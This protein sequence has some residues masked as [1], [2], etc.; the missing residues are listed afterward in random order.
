MISNANRLLATAETGLQRYTISHIAYQLLSDIFRSTADDVED[1][2]RREK[3]MAPL[4]LPAFNQDDYGKDFPYLAAIYGENV[5]IS[6]SIGNRVNGNGESNDYGNIG[7]AT[8]KPSNAGSK[9][10]DRR[11]GSSKTSAVA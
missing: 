8:K 4:P 6:T 5:V 7:K 9:S 1:S 10:G 3:G 2:Y 11:M